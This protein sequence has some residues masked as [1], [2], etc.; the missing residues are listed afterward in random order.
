[1]SPPPSVNRL[2]TQLVLSSL[3]RTAVKPVTKV[4]GGGKS[5]QAKTQ[6]L[7]R[8]ETRNEQ[9]IRYS[10]LNRFEEVCDLP[11]TCHKNFV[12]ER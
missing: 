12:F 2:I 10:S 11:Q 5:I 7:E 1:M 6:H 9:P 4:G 3:Q 8:Q